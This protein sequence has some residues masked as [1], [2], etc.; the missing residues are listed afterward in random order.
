MTIE[1]RQ[2]TCYLP[3]TIELRRAVRHHGDTYAFDEYA[4]QTTPHLLIPRAAQC[5][6]HWQYQHDVIRFAGSAQ[7]AQ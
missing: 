7:H 2:A 5:S 3:F 4:V 6:A 1:S